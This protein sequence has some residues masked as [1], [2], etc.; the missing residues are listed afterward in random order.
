M[1]MAR[2]C[3]GDRSPNNRHGGGMTDIPIILLA[4]GQS[5]RMK[6]ADKLLK[7]IDGVPL[8]RRSA[9]TALSAGPVIVALPRKP[10]ARYGVLQGLDVRPVAVPDAA[11]GMNAS[12]RQAMR[13]VPSEARAVM[14]L[15]ADLP[16][17][18]VQDLRAVVHSVSTC[19][20]NKVWRG[21]TEDGKPGH[22]VIFDRSLFGDLAALTGDS[23]AQQVVQA[24]SSQVHLVKLPGVHARLDLDTPKAWSD[25]E[26]ARSRQKI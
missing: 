8:L 18:T 13:A 17:L 15:L 21:A 25:W 4:A 11:E 6:G 7:E 23:G 22:P 1:R 26:R 16:D 14:V 9:E 10:H 5:S 24:H 12:L 19:P 3:V 20:D 2:V